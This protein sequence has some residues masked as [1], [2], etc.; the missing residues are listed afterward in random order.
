MRR[1]RCLIDPL[2]FGFENYDGIGTFRAMEAGKPI[3]A[4]R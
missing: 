4:F 3:D 2:G 1:M